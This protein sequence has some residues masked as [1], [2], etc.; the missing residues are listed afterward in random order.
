MQADIL[1]D[2]KIWLSQGRAEWGGNEVR[3]RLS[4]S[5]L[6]GQI[7]AVQAAGNA[8][9]S[10]PRIKAVASG[11]RGA[12]EARG[13]LEDSGHRHGNFDSAHREKPL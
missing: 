8:R 2:S 13:A 10:E 4:L 11:A 6:V 1:V 9:T 3:I 7:F 12:C 5:S